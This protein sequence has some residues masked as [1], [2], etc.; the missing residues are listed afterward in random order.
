MSETTFETKQLLSRGVG[1]EALSFEHKSLEDLGC[2]ADLH[3]FDQAAR[4]SDALC[5][6]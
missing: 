1:E 2:S 3:I 5:L 4:V 6:G